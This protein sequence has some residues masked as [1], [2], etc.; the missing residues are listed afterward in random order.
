MK[1]YLC[2]AAVVSPLLLTSAASAADATQPGVLSLAL[3]KDIQSKAETIV[4]KN[5]VGGS[6]AIV[7][8][9]GRLITFDR[10]DGATVASVALAQKKA[11]T[12]VAFGVTSESFQQKLAQGDMSV[13]GNPEVVP[14]GGGVPI[15]INGQ[16]VG[17]LGVST[18]KGSIDIEAANGAIAPK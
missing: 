6:V 14:L 7:D 12:A 16:V 8:A 2:A 17:A 18:P 13:L 4:A 9:A 3:A 10:M 11:Y 15:K 5:N 1:R